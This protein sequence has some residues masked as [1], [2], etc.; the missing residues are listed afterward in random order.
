[1]QRWQ[2]QVNGS[3]HRSRNF[4]EWPSTVSFRHSWDDP[5]GA[6]KW[7]GQPQESLQVPLIEVVLHRISGEQLSGFLEHAAGLMLQ[8]EY[9]GSALLS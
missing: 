3:S 5:A 1:M 2:W 8:Q 6:G 9:H 4:V 7:S